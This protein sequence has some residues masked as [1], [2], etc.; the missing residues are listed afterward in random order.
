MS[1]ISKENQK[2]L[3][4]NDYL[5]HK[6]KFVA[7]F[8]HR[9]QVRKFTGEKYFVHCEGVA[10]IIAS[11]EYTWLL[12]S[13]T[14]I[15]LICASYLHDTIE[16]TQV[17]YDFL[18]KEFNTEIADLVKMVT[19]VTTKEDGKRDFRQTVECWH[20]SKA[21]TLGK[22]LKL[23][24][25]CN[26]LSNLEEEDFKTNGN[27]IYSYKYFGEK[28]VALNY[29]HVDDNFFNDGLLQKLHTELFN[30]AKTIID[31]FFEKRNHY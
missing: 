13:E 18:Q 12:C 20:L 29:L 2:S 24:D 5:I 23:A 10:N 8:Y 7:S 14:F 1:K 4:A 26:N 19:K 30:K 17:T 9:D 15:N 6:A 21:S 31:A 27:I 25:I 22:I 11:S 28:N 16:D 3:L